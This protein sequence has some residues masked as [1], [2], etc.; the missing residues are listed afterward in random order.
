VDDFLGTSS[1]DHSP[2]PVLGL[3]LAKRISLDDDDDGGRTL[4]RF[5]GDD[6]QTT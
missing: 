2:A 6:T 3:R 4:Q 5:M 1:S